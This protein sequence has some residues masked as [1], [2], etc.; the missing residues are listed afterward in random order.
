M[1]F[2]FS[3]FFFVKKSLVEAI[4]G[5]IDLG[6][7]VVEITHDLPHID[8]MRGDFFD[9]LQLYQA[10][11]ISFSL[12]GPLFE[13]NIGSVFKELR[14]LSIERYQKAIDMASKTGIGP[15]VVHPG[16]SLLM[17]KSDHVVSKARNNFIED[18]K[19]L[20]DY[21]D[22]RNVILAL[23]NIHMPYFFFYD[24]DEFTDIHREVGN[25]GITLDIGHAYITKLQKNIDDPEGSI[26]DDI[27]RTGVDHIRHVHLHNN[28]GQKDDHF[29][30][31]GS[32]DL[33]RILGCLREMRYPGKIIIESYD[34]AQ[35]G[36]EEIKRKIDTLTS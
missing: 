20:T 26:I 22:N 27:R 4:E 9:R 5:V 13:V 15:V 1:E 29:L 3:T 8:D 14:H 34:M 18:M 12:H 31:S 25:I 36:I 17:E 2:G 32:I 30:I 21:A 33:N 35:Y 10:K 16:Y 11:G 23:E 28:A 19:R 7:S 24:L 6:M